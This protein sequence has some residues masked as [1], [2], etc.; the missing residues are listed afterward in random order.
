MTA[1]YEPPRLAAAG[2]CAEVTRGRWGRG[3]GGGGFA[4]GGF[5][6]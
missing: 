6:F 2:R 1:T 5:F 4:A 3:H